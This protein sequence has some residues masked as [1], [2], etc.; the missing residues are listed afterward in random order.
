VCRGLNDKHPSEPV[1]V[2]A[3]R[4]VGIGHSTLQA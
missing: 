3:A 2:R 1:R 4:T